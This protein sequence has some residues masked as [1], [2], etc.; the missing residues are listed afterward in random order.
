MSDEAKK[1][2][3]KTDRGGSADAADQHVKS[4]RHGENYLKAVDAAKAWPGGRQSSL[5]CSPVGLVRYVDGDPDPN[6]IGII[7]SD[8]TVLCISDAAATLH[9]NWTLIEP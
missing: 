4:G 6:D 3:R 7:F 9:M 1:L 5:R 8:G 2:A